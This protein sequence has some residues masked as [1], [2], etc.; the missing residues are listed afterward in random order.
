[1]ILL[2]ACMAGC[3]NKHQQKQFDIEGGDAKQ[4]LKEFA[5]QAEAE[6]LFDLQI[7]EG[8]R[9]HPVEGVYSP[10]NA[11]SL[12]LEN[13]N[14]TYDIEPGTGAFAIFTSDSAPGTFPD[15]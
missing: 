7:V 10:S 12:M 2:L 5:R 8:V 9:T 11:L 4:T 14:L 6:I 1:M 15:H 3:F 13:T